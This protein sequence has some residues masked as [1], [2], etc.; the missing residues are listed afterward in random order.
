MTARDALAALSRRLQSIEP[1]AAC[2]AGRGRGFGPV[3]GLMAGEP[4]EAVRRAAPN[5]EDGYPKDY[6][7][8]D[9]PFGRDEEKPTVFSR[10]A[11]CLLA[12]L[13]LLGVIL[14]SIGVRG[15]GG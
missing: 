10:A 15:F 3:V 4:Q 1:T 13:G 9:E 5:R 7:E 11:I 8:D 14:I 6:A 2:M 12:S